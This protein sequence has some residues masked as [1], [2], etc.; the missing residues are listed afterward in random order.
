MCSKSIL[1]ALFFVAAM[2]VYSQSAPAAIQSI[3]RVD[4]G[5]GVS[6]Y[7]VDFFG[8]GIMYGPTAWIDIYPNRGPKLFHGLGLDT[9]GHFISLGGPQPN[10]AGPTGNTTTSEFTYGGGPIY[11]WRHFKN[12]TPYGK[13]LWEQGIIDFNVGVPHYT[14]D[15]RSL[16]APG[17]GIEYRVIRHVVIRADYEHQWWQ[18]LFQNHQLST[19]TGIAIE[20]R[21]ITLG[22]SYQFDRLHLKGDIKE[23]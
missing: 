12:F 9:E 3:W 15:N 6:A 18:R 21:G 19:P 2:P 23:N 4:V 7:H 17:A 14:D 13:F 8:S 1:A 16:W 20:P 11:E 5:G 22:A 10:P